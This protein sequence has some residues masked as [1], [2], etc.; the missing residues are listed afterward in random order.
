MIMS[1]SA[2]NSL[3]GISFLYPRS[4]TFNRY[5][6]LYN[7]WQEFVLNVLKSVIGASKFGTESIQSDRDPIDIFNFCFYFLFATLE[8][9]IENFSFPQCHGRKEED[10]KTSVTSLD[11]LNNNLLSYFS[12][13][14]ILLNLGTLTQWCYQFLA[15]LEMNAYWWHQ[16]SMPHFHDIAGK[17]CKF[18]L[19]HHRTS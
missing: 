2:E 16:F 11:T 19:G 5:R 6:T 15:C 14:E 18:I 13:E 10:E 4:F 12:E 3:K 7:L 1:P 17:I 8:L 9:K